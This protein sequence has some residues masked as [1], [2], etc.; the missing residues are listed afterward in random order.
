MQCVFLNYGCI[1][2]EIVLHNVVLLLLMLLIHILK[3][4]IYLLES[5][6]MKANKAN[7]PKKYHYISILRSAEFENPQA[8]LI[9]YRDGRR[10]LFSKSWTLTKTAISKWVFNPYRQ[11]LGYWKSRLM[12]INCIY[13][14]K[15]FESVYFDEAKQ[16]L[17]DKW[18]RLF[19]CKLYSADNVQSLRPC[20]F[21]R[22]LAH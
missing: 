19:Q 4:K 7:S 5:R 11:G 3:G 21:H 13:R 10:G 9:V 1:F 18:S 17:K 8:C 20:I 14:P 16:V 12:K 6:K 2:L 22:N 15:W